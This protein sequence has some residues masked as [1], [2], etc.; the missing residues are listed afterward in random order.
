M[1]QLLWSIWE[2]LSTEGRAEAIK[3]ME[4]L[5]EEWERMGL[6]E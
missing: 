2:D 3:L 5:K 6:I 1:A 4:G